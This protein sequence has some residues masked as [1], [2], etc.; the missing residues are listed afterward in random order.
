LFH[1]HFAPP[2]NNISV[3]G[4]GQITSVLYGADLAIDGTTAREIG[5]TL[6]LAW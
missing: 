1:P 5:M 4:A 6:R 3:A 2:R